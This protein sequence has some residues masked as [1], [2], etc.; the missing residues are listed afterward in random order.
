[1]SYAPGFDQGTCVDLQETLIRIHQASAPELRFIKAGAVM[2]LTSELNTRGY[3]Q[4]PVDNRDGRSRNV[5]VIYVQRPQDTVVES[6]FPTDTD[7]CTPTWAPE[8]LSHVVSVEDGV[9][10]SF[11]VKLSDMRKICFQD[12]EGWIAERTMALMALLVQEMDKKVIAKMQAG[13]GT[14]V[15]GAASKT[16]ALITSNAAQYF[17]ALAI[18]DE[19]G[20]AGFQ[21]LPILIGHGDLWKYAKLTDVGCCNDTGVDLSAVNGEFAFYD[22]RNV[23]PVFASGE[24]YIALAP[25]ALQ[26]L[27]TNM[28][29]GQFRQMVPGMIEKDVI[30]DPFTGI[31][32]D[33]ARVLSVCSSKY[34]VTISKAFDLYTDPD[35]AYAATD[36][37]YGVNG[38][39]LWKKP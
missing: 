33:Y 5:E 21:N 38:S 16:V 39:F 11:D 32:F 6:G 34:T 19:M 29:E 15:G 31:K 14:F 2:A 4:I 12:T 10:A 23:D 13:M 8:P 27:G 30:I 26:L 36:D 24:N 18:Q 3:T 9:R 37:F 17:N 25:G 1:M 28:Y 7:L 22:D 20:K 35:N